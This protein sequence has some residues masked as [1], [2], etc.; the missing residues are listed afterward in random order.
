MHASVA[1]RAVAALGAALALTL[2]A[3][4]CGGE[5]V[6]KG[7]LINKMKTDQSFKELNGTQLHCVADVIVK[8]GK[9][10]A[11]NDYIAGKK[12]S[13]TDAIS[14]SNQK[15]AESAVKQCVLGK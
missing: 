12:A 2:S 8:Y 9:T 7:K 10:S 3:A 14:A 1:R 4:A 15:K 6:D 11:I 13:D 5:S